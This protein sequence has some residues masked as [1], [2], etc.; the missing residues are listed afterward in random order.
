MRETATERKDGQEGNAGRKT[1][2]FGCGA[3]SKVH[4]GLGERM[5]SPWWSEARSTRAQ[6]LPSSGEVSCVLPPRVRNRD[7]MRSVQNHV[8]TVLSKSF[9]RPKLD[10]ASHARGCPQ[11]AE[12]QEET[13]A[14][15]ASAWQGKVDRAPRSAGSSRGPAS[16]GEGR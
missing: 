6:R 12:K 1:R 10:Y 5:Q 2:G 14:R 13:A 3:R 16:G 4:L 11:A 7:E 9:V 15:P 8:S